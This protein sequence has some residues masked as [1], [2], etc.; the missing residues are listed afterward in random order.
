[1]NITELNLE[2]KYVVLKE[3]SMSAEYRD[4]TWRVVQAQGGFGCSPD[5]RGRAV[6]VEFIRDGEKTRRERFEV[7]RLATPEE[8]EAA[9]AFRV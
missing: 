9:K 7:E 6:F 5:A 1:M 4:I 2:G 3:E 8:I